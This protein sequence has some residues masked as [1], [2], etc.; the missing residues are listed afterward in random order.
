MVHRRKGRG[1]VPAR[2]GAKGDKI[3][4]V[5]ADG[6]VLVE[7]L[8]A[9][10]AGEDVVAGIVLPWARLVAKG[11]PAMSS[12]LVTSIGLVE[13]ARCQFRAAGLSMVEMPETRMSALVPSGRASWPCSQ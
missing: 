1:T 2:S 13:V 6:V 5:A 10:C 3:D 9:L 7:R 12:R 11:S 8:R 4:A